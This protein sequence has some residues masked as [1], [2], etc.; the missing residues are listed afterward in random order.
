MIAPT[1]TVQGVDVFIEG[2]GARTVVMLHGWPDTHRLWDSTV[3]ALKD[4]YRCVRFTLPGFDLSKLPVALSLR[5]IT[6]LID[7]IVETVSPNLPVTL[8]LHDWGCMFGYEFASVHT[9]R[10]AAVVAVDIGDH[11]SGDY[12][13]S[14]S[15][16]AKL[17]VFAYQIWLALAW[18][19]GSHISTR[20]ADRMTRWMAHTIGCRTP[21]ADMGWPMNYPYAMAWL[22]QSGGLKGTA[23]VRPIWPL[24]YIYGAKKPFMFHSPQ[25]L[26][27][28]TQIPG[29]CVEE[30]A[31]GH[32]VMMHQPAEFN[33]SV[34]AWLGSLT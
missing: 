2:T 16:K 13:H 27:Q 30:F 33:A 17:G 29:N 21:P 7:S 1:H 14:L 8:L 4:Q 22:G 12:L 15:S 25:W 26:A 32:W 9:H 20:L 31:T 24:L 34:K 10:I 23:P 3:D 11:N 6:A 28:V 5:E 18:I 19:I